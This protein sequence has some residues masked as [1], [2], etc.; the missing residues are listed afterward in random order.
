[1]LDTPDLRGA[2]LSTHPRDGRKE[3]GR[4]PGNSEVKQ[5]AVF[6]LVIRLALM[7]DYIHYGLRRPGEDKNQIDIVMLNIFMILILM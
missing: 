5:H 3:H 7:R 4:G 1:M 2:V 6:T